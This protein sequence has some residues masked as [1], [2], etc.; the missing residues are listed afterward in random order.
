MV[1]ARD[2]SCASAACAGD[3]KP[4][5]GFVRVMGEAWVSLFDVG[6]EDIYLDEICL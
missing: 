6:S 2:Y 4:S 5:V 3:D 1:F